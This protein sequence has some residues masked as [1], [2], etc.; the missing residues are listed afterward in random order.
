MSRALFE[1]AGD[2]VILG[3]GDVRPH[4]AG[5]LAATLRG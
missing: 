3:C 5:K 1:R 2:V 4:I